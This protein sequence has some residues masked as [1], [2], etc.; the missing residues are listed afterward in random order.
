MLL[1]WLVNAAK[2][3]LMGAQT[4]VQT[5]EEKSGYIKDLY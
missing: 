1:E 2:T 4:V 5:P 3:M